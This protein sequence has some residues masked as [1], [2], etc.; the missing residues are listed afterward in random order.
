MNTIK[1]V[2]NRK[3]IKKKGKDKLKQKEKCKE[4]RKRKK[5]VNFERIHTIFELG[6]F[7]LH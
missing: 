7:R 4:E 5:V 2:E 1:K 3:K 6:I